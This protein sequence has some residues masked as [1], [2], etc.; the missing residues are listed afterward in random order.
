MNPK[1]KINKPDAAWLKRLRAANRLMDQPVKS[2][3]KTCLPQKKKLQQLKDILSL[4][5]YAVI[6]P[7][8]EQDLQNM[9]DRGIFIYPTKVKQIPGTSRQCHRNSALLWKNNKDASI[10]TG[11]ALSDDGL[12]RQHTW[13]I[14]NKEV[15]ESTTQRVLYFGYVL[16]SEEAEKFYAENI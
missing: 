10:V 15:W 1:P 11:Y 8:L 7:H 16:N 5:G 2:C 13:C 4:H 12:W 9:L 3:C 6:F 14:M